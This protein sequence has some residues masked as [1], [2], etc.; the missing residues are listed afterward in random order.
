M[1]EIKNTYLLTLTCT[2]EKLSF[3][4]FQRNAWTGFRYVHVRT[5][6]SLNLGVIWFRRICA[7]G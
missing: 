2:Q 6:C 3:F 5:G 4:F 7:P 1:E